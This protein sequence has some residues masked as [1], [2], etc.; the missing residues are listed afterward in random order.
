MQFIGCASC[1]AGSQLSLNQSRHRLRSGYNIGTEIRSSGKHGGLDRSHRSLRGVC[2]FLVCNLFHCFRYV[3]LSLMAIC[4]GYRQ[5]DLQVHAF[6]LIEQP[7]SRDI[8]GLCSALVFRGSGKPDA[9][10]FVKVIA[11]AVLLMYH[12]W[13]YGTYQ[14]HNLLTFGI[15]LLSILPSRVAC[16]ATVIAR[17]DLPQPT[18]IHP[19]FRGTELLYCMDLLALGRPQFVGHWRKR[20]SFVTQLNLS[21]E[22]YWKLMHTACSQRYGGDI[23]LCGMEA[24]LKR[25]LS[26]AVVF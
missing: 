14:T 3:Y 8:I 18:W 12:L 4:R 22:S 24:Q 7:P 5:A 1:S 21:R 16:W 19:S 15:L 23:F 13:R 6:R 9:T 20:F 10:C 17:F 2:T 25:H 11:T 26:R